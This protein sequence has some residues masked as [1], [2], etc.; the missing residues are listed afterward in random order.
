MLA[1]LP[2]RGLEPTWFFWPVPATFSQPW[3]LPPGLAP[4]LLPGGQLPLGPLPLTPAEVALGGGPS[5]ST[6]E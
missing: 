1:L 2:R 5:P 6:S 4:P 3:N